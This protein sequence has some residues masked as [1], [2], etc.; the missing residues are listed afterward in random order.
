M[1]SIKLFQTAPTGTLPVPAGGSRTRGRA[2]SSEGNSN[3]ISYGDYRKLQDALKS[4]LDIAES[5]IKTD[6]D[7][8]K[9]EQLREKFL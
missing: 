4:A 6:A 3:W 1:I 2:G 9:L 8:L 5:N 7:I